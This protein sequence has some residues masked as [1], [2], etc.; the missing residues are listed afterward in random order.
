M[1]AFMM[2]IAQVSPLFERVPP[3]AYGGTE[4]V[5]SYLTEELVRQGHEVTLFA[6][7]DSITD[8]RLVPAAEQSLRPEPQGH[9]W[10]AYHMIEMDQV[11]AMVNEF[12]VVHFH[13][14]YMHFSLLRDFPV[15]HVTTVHGRLD[16]PELADLFR[17][18]VDVPLVSI[19]NS[20]RKPL[21]SA[22][23]CETVY[24]GVPLNL[25]SL[26]VEHGNYFVFI[27]RMSPEKR[28][29]RAIDIARRCGMRLY[30]AAKIDKMDE[31]YFKEKIEPLLN[32]PGIEYVGEI[33]E[34][35]KRE[36]LGRA[37]ALL[38]PIDW[39]EPFGMVMIEAF[40]SGTPVIAYRNGSIPEIVSDGENGFVVTNQEEA[41]S[42]AK[43]IE[44]IDRK[45]CREIFEQRFT[46]THMAENYLSVYR[47]L[48]AQRRGA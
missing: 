5:V 42:A 41:V 30:I 4:R 28:V 36:L 1:A 9:A 7:A 27:G 34:A 18:Y 37:T 13:T 43:R 21:P 19:S 47:G 32:Q 45:R 11:R 39:P 35:E 40:A 26:H 12:D 15:A 14:D 46:S 8:A 6:S 33:G 23:W 25:Y 3:K 20:Q 17:H 38:F 2:R 31:A 24:H 29:D 16:L 48:C 44:S 10:L 22:R